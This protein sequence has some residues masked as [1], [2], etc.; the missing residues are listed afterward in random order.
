MMNHIEN[1]LKIERKNI[2]FYFINLD[3]RTDRLSHVNS[4]LKKHNIDAKR[5]R[6]Y[7]DLNGCDISFGNIISEGQ[8]R[9]YRSHYTLI[10]EYDTNSDKVLGVFEDDVIFCE[11]FDERFEYIE[12]NFNLNWDIF[13]LSSFYHLNDDP[14]RWNKGGD[15]ELTGIKY[16]HRV[17]GSF[18]GHSYLINPRSIPKIIKLL[19][20]CAHQSRAID[21]SFI[22]IEP[23]LNCYSFTPGM[24][25]QLTNASDTDGGIKDQNAFLK[26]IGPHYYAN[27]LSDFNYDSYFK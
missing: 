27:K 7:E 8:K 9:C 26:I 17:Y 23:L 15:Y 21:H 3:R 2:D 10:K 24:A 6:A 22:L 14:Q 11:D 18:C 1:S 4:E 12:K 5:F 19:D 25:N 20:D 13:F 16:I